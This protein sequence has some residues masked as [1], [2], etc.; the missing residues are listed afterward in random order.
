MIFY[1]DNRPSDSPFVERI[2]YT[3]SDRTGS[4]ISQAESLW[5]MVVTKYQGTTTFTVRGPETKASVADV[6]WT[7]AEFFG[8]TFKLG[9]FM[10]HL[11]PGA[12]MDRNDL[13][14]PEANS[15]SVWLNGS[16]WQIPDFENADTFVE[17]L[18]REGMLVR[19]PIVEATLQGHLKDVS[20]RSVQRR[21][22]RATGLT[23]GTVCQI[24]RAHR[25]VALLQQGST[26]LDA[27][28]E[29]GYSDQ[30]HLTRSL[31]R[32]TGQTP[33]QFL[34]LPASE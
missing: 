13:N 28:Y 21:F 18:V 11:P 17:R 27:V 16:A 7:E 3:Q 34:G 15:Q 10:P 25:A 14:L 9:T 33:A 24:Q 23:H 4:F 19:E 26:I 29:A 20:L 2:W 8:I 30:P 32:F 1:F 12:V 22:L 6:N 31:K 5:E